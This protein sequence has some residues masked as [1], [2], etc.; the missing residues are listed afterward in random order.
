MF[1]VV[2]VAGKQFK[3]SPKDRIT[4]PSLNEKPGTKLT[5]DRVLLVGDEKTVVVGNPLVAGAHVEGTILEHGKADKVIV[6]KKKRRKG[7]R[8]KRGHRQG[9][10][11]IEILSIAR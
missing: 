2:E 7:Y 3:V 8:L 10:T 5:L 11:Q 9:I 1:A 4:V 6:F